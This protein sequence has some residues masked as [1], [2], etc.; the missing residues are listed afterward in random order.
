MSVRLRKWKGKGGKLHE[1]WW[2][3]V[4]YQHPTGRLVRVRKASPVNTR[5]GAEEYER[6]IRHSLL[7]GT[8][9]KEK[10][11]ERT[12][13]FAEFVAR[14]LTYCENNNKPS[15][16]ACKKVVLAQHILG[17]RLKSGQTWTGQNRPKARTRDW[18]AS[19]PS[20]PDE[21][22]RSTVFASCAART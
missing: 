2:V 19:T 22:S 4:K 3:D 8:F 10:S 16:L 1:A 13:T 9:G 14:F 15:T 5:R 20:P 7:T 21:T 17:G 6:Q 18:F 12:P 11:Q